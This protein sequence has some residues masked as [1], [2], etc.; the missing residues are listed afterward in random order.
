MQIPLLFKLLKGG[1]V[2]NGI[3]PE[4]QRMAQV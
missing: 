3:N 4:L 2:E 1:G